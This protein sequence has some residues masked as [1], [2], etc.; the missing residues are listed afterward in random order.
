MKKLIRLALQILQKNEEIV[1]ATIIKRQGS[2]PREAG[3]KI[4]IRNDGSFI[5]TIGGGL[6]ESQVIETAKNVFKSGQS[7]L[8]SFDMTH[9]QMETGSM[10]CGGK[11]EV[12]IDIFKPNS[13]DLSVLQTIFQAYTQQNAAFTIT[14]IA[15]DQKKG[16]QTEHCL[17]E[18]SGLIKGDTPFSHELPD[19]IKTQIISSKLPA[20]FELEETKIWVEP[21]VFPKKLFIFGAG[22]VSRPTA[23]LSAS[24]GFQVIVLDDRKEFIHADFF[25]EPIV[26]RAVEDFNFCLDDL[27]INQNSYLVIVTR[28]HFYDKSILSQALKTDAEYIGMIGSRTKRDKIYSYLLEEGFKQEDLNRVH[29]PIGLKMGAETPEEIAISIVAELVNTRAKNR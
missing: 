23:A 27:N 1:I 25:P 26:A 28:G 8:N 6:I 16:C 4:V 17:L 14:S 22:H 15:S 2:A 3:T 10:I 29:S 7:V 9:E 11:V 19:S 24:V 21:L 20:V 12:L 18:K 5:G 13:P